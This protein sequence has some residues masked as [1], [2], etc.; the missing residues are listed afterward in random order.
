MDEYIREVIKKQKDKLGAT[1]TDLAK[2]LNVTPQAV[3]Q[4]I[5]GD[6]GKIPLS[7]INLLDALNL[8][9]VVEVQE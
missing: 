1:N 9:L 7:L 3:G 8:K 5:N 2:K 6:R 4:L